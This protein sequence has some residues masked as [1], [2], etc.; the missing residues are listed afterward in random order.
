VDD[1]PVA[2]DDDVSAAPR[3]RGE[4]LAKLGHEAELRF[5]AGFTARAGR[6]VEGDDAEL[7]EAQLDVAAL[8]VELFGAESVDDFVRLHSAEDGDAAM[9]FAFARLVETPIARGDVVFELLRARFDFLETDEVGV[10]IVEPV[11]E[12]LANTGA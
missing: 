11:V 4:V 1:V 2:G 7:A 6:G 12:A 9:A 10:L 3:E 8:G 5:E